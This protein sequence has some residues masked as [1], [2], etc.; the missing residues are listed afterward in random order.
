[1]SKWRAKALELFPDMK[2]DIEKAD[3]VGMLWT[4]LWLRFCSYYEASNSC[5]QQSELIRAIYLYAA[6]CTC[7]KSVDTLEA[8]AI[9][10]YENVSWYAL[11]C[12]PSIHERVITDL[13][14]SIGLPGIKGMAGTFAYLIGPD[15]LRQF[16]ADCEQADRDLRRRSQ[17]R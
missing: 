5:R 15:G 6:W 10:F 14:K 3:S 16:L 2:A 12:P 1:L 11:R 17:K 8:A 7:A 4:E 9:G 13:V